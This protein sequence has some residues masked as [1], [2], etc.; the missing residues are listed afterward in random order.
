[1][2]LRSNHLLVSDKLA[3]SRGVQPKAARDQSQQCHTE[4]VAAFPLKT[5]LAKEFFETAV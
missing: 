2:R 3:C 1:M 4:Q 5:G